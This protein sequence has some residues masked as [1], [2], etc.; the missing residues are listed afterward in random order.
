MRDDTRRDFGNPEILDEFEN[1]K[2][3]MDKEGIS[4]ERALALVRNEKENLA[5][6]DLSS[7]ARDAMIGLIEEKWNSE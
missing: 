4:F 2:R 1:I 7:D 6:D 5:F 3:M